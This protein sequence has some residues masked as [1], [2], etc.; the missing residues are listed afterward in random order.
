MLCNT[1]R[2][3]EINLFSSITVRKY[4]CTHHPFFATLYKIVEKNSFRG[5]PH[6]IGG[7]DYFNS[8]I[9]SIENV[10]SWF[11]KFMKLQVEANEKIN[12]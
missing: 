3:V 1:A 5:T 7:R 6:P 10:K 12:L 9:E 4:R 11:L 2:A 8:L